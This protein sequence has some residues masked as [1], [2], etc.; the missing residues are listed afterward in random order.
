MT[1]RNKKAFVNALWDWGFLDRCFAPTR[2]RVSDLDGVV[3]RNSQVLFI[4]AKPPGK[5]ISRGQYL[6][7]SGL[8]R[9]GFSV[10]VIWGHTNSPEEAMIWAPGE[11]N[12]GK[13]MKANE[14]KIVEIVS[15][16]F[17]WANKN[18]WKSPG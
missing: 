10:L 2:G 11:E 1:I 17:A 8:A 9:R 3:E 18:P 13:R 6:L 16:W 7:F 5:S 15:R 12:P 14:A 4:E